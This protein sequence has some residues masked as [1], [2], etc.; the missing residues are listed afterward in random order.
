MFLI[1]GYEFY[2]YMYLCVCFL[3]VYICM[4]SNDNGIRCKCDWLIFI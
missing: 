1:F 2:I 4:V 3:V